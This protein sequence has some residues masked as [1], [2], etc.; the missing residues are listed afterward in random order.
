MY[1][2]LSQDVLKSPQLRGDFRATLRGLRPPDRLS[3]QK[4]FMSEHEPGLSIPSRHW[5]L[6]QRTDAAHGVA[7]NPPTHEVA[8][9]F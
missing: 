9:R 6:A 8:E 4:T 2:P 3:G 5:G 1:A 7:L